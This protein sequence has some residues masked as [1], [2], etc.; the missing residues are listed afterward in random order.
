MPYSSTELVVGIGTYSS[1]ELVVGM[2]SCCFSDAFS[3]TMFVIS[4][5]ESSL[6]KYEDTS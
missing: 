4:D 6:V 5:H 2:C 1:I 3:E